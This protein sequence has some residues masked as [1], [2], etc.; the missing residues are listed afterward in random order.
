VLADR[1]GMVMSPKQLDELG[2]DFGSSEPI[3]LLA[4]RPVKSAADNLM[5][6]LPDIRSHEAEPKPTPDYHRAADAYMAA[7]RA[8]LG[9][10][11]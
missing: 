10:P 6:S 3:E 11:D 4:P 2:A 7:A 9:A 5:R 8:D 1:S